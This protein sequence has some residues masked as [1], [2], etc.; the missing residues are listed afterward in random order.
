MEAAASTTE[1]V[2]QPVL[3]TDQ[4]D[5]STLAGRVSFLHA[6]KLRDVTDF[7]HAQ[8]IKKAGG[9]KSIARRKRPWHM[10]EIMSNIGGSPGYFSRIKTG[11]ADNP[12]IKWCENV[13]HF[14]GVSVAWLVEGATTD[15]DR[16]FEQDLAVSHLVETEVPQTRSI[17]DRLNDLFTVVRP[18][19]GE[20]EYTCDDVA[21]TVGATPECIAGIREGTVTEEEISVPLAWR[22][23]RFFGAPASYLSAPGDDAL[24]R[25]VDHQLSML[26]ELSDTG[27]M[28]MALKAKNTQG[29]VGI[30]EVF[31]RMGELILHMNS[32]PLGTGTPQTHE[33]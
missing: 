25:Q 33:G 16:A 24:V 27:L 18:G 17:A 7:E 11:K 8:D 19:N 26:R 29:S 32:V 6:K 12:G 4:F 28:E 20:A 2:D 30:Y 15:A 23:S 5:L 1:P 3:A 9:N 13:A 21:R 10:S 22:L 31:H 14:F